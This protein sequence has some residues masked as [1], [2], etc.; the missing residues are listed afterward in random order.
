MNKIILLAGESN[1]STALTEVNGMPFID[2]QIQ[3]LLS[4]NFEIYVVVDTKSSDLIIRNSKKLDECE[5]VYDANYNSS[6]MTNFRS[7][8]YVTYNMSF[9]LPL[10]E[11]NYP[12]EV[13]KKLMNN[14][15]K[16]GSNTNFHMFQT[17]SI[18]NGIFK[19]IFPI[20]ITAK[21]NH[22]LRHNKSIDNLNE[23]QLH[24][25]NGLVKPASEPL[26]S[27]QVWEAS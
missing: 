20:L 12:K 4:L 8:L 6:F 11:F 7:A 19:P 17:H 21:G 9:I 3:N 24:I 16:F 22:Y 25:Y 2:W 18:K 26:L 14:Y 5:L 1:L 13:Y 23:N 27:P 15:L 10:T